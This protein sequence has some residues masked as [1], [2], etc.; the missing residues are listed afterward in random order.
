MLSWQDTVFEERDVEECAGIEHGSPGEEKE[1]G[2]EQAAVNPQGL[3]VLDQKA[4]VLVDGD[5]REVLL[6]QAPILEH[7]IQIR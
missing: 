6:G 1:R 5:V 3:G 7:K 4:L 2:L